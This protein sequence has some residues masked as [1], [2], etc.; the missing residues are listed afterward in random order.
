VTVTDDPVERDLEDMA[1]DP[2]LAKSIRRS[3]EQLRNGSAG[4]DLAEMAKDV[5]DGRT[6]LRMVARSAAYAN[7]ITAGIGRYKSWEAQL[8]PEERAAFEQEAR[9]VIYGDTDGRS[10][11]DGTD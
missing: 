6:D 10:A 7:D 3:L 5:L 9:N 4:P 2:K 8:S 11:S 1:G